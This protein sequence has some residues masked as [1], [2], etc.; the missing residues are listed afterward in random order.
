VSGSQSSVVVV[1]P[2]SWNTLVQLAELPDARPQTVYAEHSWSTL[3]GTSAG[4]ALHL[5]DLSVPVTL[6][7]VVGAD[8]E[9]TLICD[10]LSHDRIT[11]VAERVDGA[12]ERHLN[13]MAEGARLSIYL[14]LPRTPVNALPAATL[15]ATEAADH[16]VLDLSLRTRS[17]IGA[18]RGS[19]ATVWT[20]LHNYDG[21]SAFHR[22]FLDAADIVFLS[23]EALGDPRSFMAEVLS[24]G[25]R[26]VVCTLG[27]E[28]A[29]ALDSRGWH[30]VAAVPMEVID[31]NGAGDAFL[32]GFLAATRKG[33]D[34]QGCLESGAGQA[35]RALGTPHL[36]P[37]LDDR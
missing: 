4:K 34:V 19:G 16:V 12:S 3:G 9:A 2:A 33:V 15:Q 18:A 24:A 10:A 32:A 5:A 11:L 1:G 17:V 31:T 28:G 29:I 21:E 30:R 14:S 6:S 37:L 35:A 36:S 23:N 7:T 13:L 25:K 27:A 8:T 26:L 22:P 20:D